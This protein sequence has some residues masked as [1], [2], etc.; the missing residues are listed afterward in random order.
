MYEIKQ[1]HKQL[2]VF[3]NGKLEAYGFNTQED[4]LHAIWQL[5]GANP[6]V[7]YRC[8]DNGSVSVD[9]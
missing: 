7:F 6:E 5:N 2:A 1:N 8:D 4:A 3:L 9:E